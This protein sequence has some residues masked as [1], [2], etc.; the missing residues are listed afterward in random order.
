M[1]QSSAF[2]PEHGTQGIKP[3][4]ANAD[5]PKQ[6][7]AFRPYVSELFLYLDSAWVGA[8]DEGSLWMGLGRAMRCLPA[9]GPDQVPSDALIIQQCTYLLR[10]NSWA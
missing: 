2:A 6:L 4:V 3:S 5:A 9:D 7:T 1:Q 10:S 8:A